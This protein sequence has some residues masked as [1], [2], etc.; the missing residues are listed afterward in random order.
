[1]Y[2]KFD[3]SKIKLKPLRE[4]KHDTLLG[5]LKALECTSPMAS[6]DLDQ[7]AGQIIE[8]RKR[9]SA[10][11]VLMGAHVIKVGMSRF[12][13]DLMERGYINHLGLNGAGVIHDYELALVGGTSEACS[14]T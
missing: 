7:I 12:I 2:P 5:D 1:M 4:R 6:A 14:A 9:G 11:I 10:V 3:V 8:A 13:I